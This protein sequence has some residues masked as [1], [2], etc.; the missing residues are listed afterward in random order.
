MPLRRTASYARAA[1]G[2][3]RQLTDPPC[4]GRR[5]TRGETREL[6]LRPVAQPAVHVFPPP[7]GVTAVLVLS[8]SHLACHT[9]PESGYA[10]FNLYCCRERPDWPWAERLTEALGAAEVRVRRLARPEAP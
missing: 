7:G 10:A 1:R 6:D 5:R 8:E 3:I 2:G 9:F 4:A